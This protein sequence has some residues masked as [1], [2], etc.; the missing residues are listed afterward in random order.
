MDAGNNSSGREGQLPDL[1]ALGPEALKALVLAQRS[2]LDSRESEIE[3]LKLLILKLKRMQFGP[4]SE[5][6]SRDIE[7]RKSTR[8]NSSHVAISYAGFCLKR[9]ADRHRAR[10]LS[11]GCRCGN[12]SGS[13]C[14]RASSRR[15][16]RA[17]ERGAVARREPHGPAVL[18]L[19]M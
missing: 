1:D 7:D 19:V 10:G 13:A 2:E 3:S 8:L 9:K 12:R 4:R 17:H 14:D 16:L 6:F 11:R 15:P 5:K 18:R